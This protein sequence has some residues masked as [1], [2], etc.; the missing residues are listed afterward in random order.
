LNAFP[1]GAT[2][3][4]ESELGRL[5]VSTI[6]GYD[7]ARGRFFELPWGALVFDLHDRWRP[8]VR[9]REDFERITQAR[10]P[11]FFNSNHTENNLEGRSD[12]KG[13]EPEGITVAELARG[14]NP[15]VERQSHT[16]PT[17]VRPGQ[18]SDAIPDRAFGQRMMP[19]A[20]VA[21]GNQ[22]RAAGSIRTTEVGAP[23]RSSS[24]R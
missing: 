6:D 21:P 18:Y 5:N 7:D 16:H 2:L 14:V 23:P 4:S 10:Y 15:S 24:A 22:R 17:T 8:G 19:V 3:I 11:A 12:D 9:Q 20:H 1:D 13:P